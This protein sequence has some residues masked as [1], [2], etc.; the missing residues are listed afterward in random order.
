MET[1]RQAKSP[2]LARARQTRESN[3]AWRKAVGIK[4]WPARANS[5]A[6]NAAP[7]LPGITQ[8][9]KKALP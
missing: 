7:P 1:M 4:K 3:V 8:L 9:L 5:Q 6:L 2:T